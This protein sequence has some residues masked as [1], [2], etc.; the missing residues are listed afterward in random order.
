MATTCRKPG[1]CKEMEHALRGLSR[2]DWEMA[3]C[4][5]NP[6]T[7]TNVKSYKSYTCSLC[8][9]REI[10]CLKQETKTKKQQETLADVLEMRENAF[11][12]RLV[13]G[14]IPNHVHLS[15]S[16]TLGMKILV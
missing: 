14:N 5:L 15:S 10:R 2:D 9:V 3:F 11:F 8:G 1:S 7:H 12:F 16:R 13:L 6:K 4:L